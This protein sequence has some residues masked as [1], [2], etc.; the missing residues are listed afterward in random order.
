MLL[1]FYIQQNRQ[2]AVEEFAKQGGFS[3]HLL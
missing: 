2:D 3:N 1:G